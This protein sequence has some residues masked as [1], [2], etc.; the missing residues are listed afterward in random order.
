MGNTLKSIASLSLARGYGTVL[1]LVSLVLTSRYL[2]P[3]GR[4][5]FIAALGWASLFGTLFSF[6]VGQGLQSRFQSDGANLSEAEVVGTLGGLCC[7]FSFIGVFVALI[8]YQV[9]G[10]ELFHGIPAE[11]LLLAF[12]VMPGLIWEQYLNNILACLS[13]VR[14]LSRSLYISRTIG[15][16]GVALFV[17]YLQWGVR[18]ALFVTIMSQMLLVA[19][20]TIPLLHECKWRL[21]WDRKE[22]WEVTKTGFKLHM[23]SVC[24][25]LLEQ[26]SVLIVNHHLTKADVGHYQLSIQLVGL[27]LIV[28]QSAML[29]IYGGMA[30][31]DPDSYWPQQR[32]IM[33]RVMMLLVVAVFVAW[34]LGPSLIPIV[35]G[36][37]FKETVPLFVLQLPCVLGLSLAVLMT[38]QWVARGLFALNNALTV[39]TTV[40]VI[41]A[42]LLAVPRYG[43][44]GAV[45]V[46]LFVYALL[47]PIVQLVFWRW[48]GR[49]QRS[50]ALERDKF[51]GA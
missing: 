13:K 7:L 22:A 12:C 33:L 17:G 30:K 38:P 29:V 23:T 48:C 35:A 41:G 25:F 14:Y 45:G 6:S 8:G 15:V 1:S 28:P 44:D 47:I 27:M 5:A 16:V 37:S 21:G 24:A 40:L 32:K 43:L 39:L 42:S 18:G 50:L 34:V 26:A 31:S 10:G 36:Q 49:R 20:G 11:V 4:G 2:G 9:S 19:V 46:R 51:G 3:S